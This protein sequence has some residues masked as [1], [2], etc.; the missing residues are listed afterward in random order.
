MHLR[1][2][3]LLTL[4]AAPLRAQDFVPPDAGAANTG[5]R[6]GLYGFGT[7][8]GLDLG[9]RKQAVGGVSIDAGHLFS[10][11]IRIR[12]S[13]EV[14][15]GRGVNTYL[16]NLELMYR[17][18]SDGEVAVPYLGFGLGVWGEGECATALNCPAVWPQFALGFELRIRDQL[19]WMVEYHAE[20]TFSRHRMFI[21]L[22]TRRPS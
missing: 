10:D 14:G 9:G 5:V 11:R 3:V 15:M 18:T 13:A 2:A 19:N 6:L 7:R 8:L 21:G 12:P 20:D 16:L 17:F 1:L 4:L 22:I